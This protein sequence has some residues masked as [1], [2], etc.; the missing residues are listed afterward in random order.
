[1]NYEVMATRI[2]MPS[3]VQTIMGLIILLLVLEGTRRAWGM[4][5]PIVVIC[6]LL[7][8]YFGQ[9]LPSIFN[10]GGMS[11]D[12]LIGY[13]ATNFQGVF[14]SLTALGLREVFMFVVLGATLEASGAT[15]F[16]M[17][18]ARGIG[19]RLR[20]GPAQ[21]A[22]VGSAFMGSVQGNITSN[23]ATTGAITIPL[24]RKSGYTKEH[25][26]AIEAAAS[27]GSQIVPPVMGAAA[28]VMADTTGIP[29][30]EIILIAIVPAIIYYLFLSINAQFEAMKMRL[31]K[32]EKSQ[33]NE[34]FKAIKQEGYLM[35]SL[36]VLIYVLYIGLPVAV[37]ALYTII[38]LF[39]LVLVK[40]IIVHRFNFKNIT[41]EMGIFLFKSLREGAINGTKLGLIMASLGVMVEMFVVTGFAQR[42]SNQM[43][44]IAGNSLTILLLLVALTCIL[45]GMGMPTT[46]AYITVS[47]LAAPALIQFGVP[48]VAAHFFV[49]YYA[50]MAAVTPP[51]G[52]AAIV[53]TGIS[54][55]KY[56]TTAFISTK[57]ALPGFILPF[58]FVFRPEI[59]LVSDNLLEIIIAGLTALIGIVSISCIF[60]RYMV[61]RLTIWEMVFL[62]LTVVISFIPSILFS[63]LAITI[64]AF[65]LVVQIRKGPIVAQESQNVVSG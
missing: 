36:V 40:N 10:H 57:L 7:Y 65:V 60:A 44:S 30:A 51:I 53:A 29:Y 32:G 47:V 22:I 56:M 23:V 21:S 43:I 39:F 17:K 1:M 13:A 14:G 42:I 31:Q 35:I 52:S 45:F 33:R 24:M 28:F 6:A 27:T 46:G 11:F 4:V 54:G 50:L 38:T 64:F 49:L 55:G 2:G 5:I 12:R 3:S 59:L 20:S 61:N 25:A 41:K 19:G 58:I 8:A 63:L 26:G 62:A 9:L 34:A 37:A 16:F 15:E 18:I 48:L